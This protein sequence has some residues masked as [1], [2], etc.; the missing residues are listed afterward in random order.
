VLATAIQHAKLGRVP[1]FDRGVKRARFA[2]LRGASVPAVLIEGGFM[3]NPRD[4][5]MLHSVEWRERLAESVADGILE[6]VN[7]TKKGTHPKMLARYRAEGAELAAGSG[8]EYQ[9]L[10]G[11]ARLVRPKIPGVPGWRRLLPAPLGEEMPPFK[12]EYEPAGWVQLEMWAAAGEDARSAGQM[13]ES[14]LSRPREWPDPAPAW[15]NLRGWRSLIPPRGAEETF[16]LFVSPPGAPFDPES[17][18]ENGAAP[19]WNLEISGKAL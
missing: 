6:F 1:M 12:M 3:S 11:I 19:D 14:F 4:A 13:E 9:P 2:V 17:G 7:L 16:V 8:F 18:R 15:P 10:E 5:R